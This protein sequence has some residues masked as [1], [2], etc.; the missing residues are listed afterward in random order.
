MLIKYDNTIEGFY[1]VL[2][3]V[4]KNKI[5]PQ[6]I[7][8]D[9]NTLFQTKTLRIKTIQKI[10]DYIFDWL[11][12]KFSK[13]VHK[14][15]YYVFLSN[16]PNKEVFIIKY[17]NL[18]NKFGEKLDKTYKSE[19]INVIKDYYKKVSFE[20]HRFKGLIRFKELKNGY[21]YSIIEPDHNILP[22]ISHHFSNR[23]T[24]ENFIIHDT[25]R[26]F[27]YVHDNNIKDIVE[28]KNMDMNV[29][30]FYSDD[31]FIFQEAWK[32]YHKHLSIKERY[33]PKLQRNFMPKRYWKNL[34]E[35]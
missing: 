1:C 10:S 5:K 13:K 4:Y 18:I 15:V 19:V 35:F 32:I 11:N 2:Y 6:D 27:A 26:S 17:L 22:I 24:Y 34:T 8:F 9:Q 33:N 7:T 29:D 25:K 30:N 23:L 20:S 3:Y 14:K 28:I 12:K 16:L 31:E 21:F